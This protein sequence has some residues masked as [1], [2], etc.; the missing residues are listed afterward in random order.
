VARQKKKMASLE[1]RARKRTVQQIAWREWIVFGSSKLSDQYPE[2]YVKLVDRSDG[3][4]CSCFEHGGGQFRVKT[5]CSH[6]VAVTIHRRENPSKYKKPSDQPSDTEGRKQEPTDPE[7]VAAEQHGAARR[8]EATGRGGEVEASHRFKSVGADTFPEEA[9]DI[10]DDVFGSPPFPEKFTEF[11][12]NQW[13]AIV[14]I[15]EHLESGKKVVMLSAPTGSGKT[16]IAESVRR[17]H[18]G[19]TVYSCTTK[20]LQDQ[21]Q[22][23]FD[24]ART[25][26][27]R[28]NYPTLARRDLTA[29]DCQGSNSNDYEC[30]WCSI[31]EGRLQRD[32]TCPYWVAKWDAV[33]APLPILNIAYFLGE[34]KNER[35]SS[36]RGRELVIIDEA[37]TLEEQLMSNIE[38]VLASYLRRQIGVYSLPKKTVA[39][40]W[41]RWLEDEVVPGIKNLEGRLRVE[42]RTLF[43]ES[44]KKKRQI[45]RL[46]MLLDRI[47]PLL[48]STDDGRRSIEDG[49]V[50]TGYEGNAKDMSIR[51][52]PI[53]VDLHAH[54]VLWNRG[55]QF[56]LMSATLISPAQMASDLGLEEDEWAVVHLDSTFPVENRPVFVPAVASMTNKT[57]KEAWPVMAT[58]IEAII[59]ENPNVRILIHTVSYHLTK[60]LH[61]NMATTRTIMYL[62]ARERERTLENFL[63][64]DDA[65]L[66]AP[67]FE[68][69]I[70]LPEEDCGIIIIAKVPYPYLGDKQ[71]SARMYGKGGQV[72]YAVQTIRA[73]VQM[74]GRGMRSK[75]DWCDTFIMDSQFRRVY[76]DNQRLF[77][78]WWRDSLVMSMTDPKNKKMVKAMRGRRD[79]R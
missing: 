17:L 7:K 44:V 53:K 63:N 66:L 33:D 12:P 77:P 38:V 74:T 30:S 52:K 47:K 75:E 16:I 49:W 40:D 51:F 25:I 54:N 23:D 50:M 26:K 3:Y 62:N 8:G 64:K 9:L 65:V 76:R 22:R 13:D 61:D 34:T 67:S 21:I 37:D 14:E 28:A 5:G 18:A 32:E 19:R 20:S 6:V 59:K 71:I 15:M 46:D 68:R 57:K 10:D 1:I 29:E 78:K 70:D 41:V 72:W 79:K 73:L 35:A 48:E 42:A 31:S 24:Y 43:G 56:L 4:W 58:E 39:G 27:G 55:D 11:R 45:K 2:Y 60:Y 36:F 69:G